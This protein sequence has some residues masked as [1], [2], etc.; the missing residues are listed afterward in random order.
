MLVQMVGCLSHDG[1]L[2]KLVCSETLALR[3]LLLDQRHV[4]IP[5]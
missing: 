2:S 3:S 5:G 1:H 4:T